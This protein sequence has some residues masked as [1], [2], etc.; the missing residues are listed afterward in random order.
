MCVCVCLCMC[1]FATQ[2]LKSPAVKYK[3]LR[4]VFFSYQLANRKRDQQIYK[5]PFCS[6]SP[7]FPFFFGKKKFTDGAALLDSPEETH[8]K[9]HGKELRRGS[10]KEM[11]S[12]EKKTVFTKL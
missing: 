10:K 2:Y 7:E 11:I 6:F 1:F 5:C 8:C 4:V 3:S 12:T 9:D